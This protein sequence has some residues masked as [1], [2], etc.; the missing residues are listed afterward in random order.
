MAKSEKLVFSSMGSLLGRREH[1]HFGQRSHSSSPQPSHSGRGLAW[2]RE[3]GHKVNDVD[4]W[5]RHLGRALKGIN[6]HSMDKILVEGGYA[7]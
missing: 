2:A 4:Q 5:R 6:A 1:A 3:N 7:A